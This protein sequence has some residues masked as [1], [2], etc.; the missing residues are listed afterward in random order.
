MAADTRDAVYEAVALGIGVGFM[1][2]FGTYRSDTLRRIRV[3]EFAS[4]VDEV[5]FA[6]A[7]ERNSLVD[8]FFNVARQLRPDVLIQI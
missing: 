3:P 6:L 4:T 1:W 5:V 8:L 2:R 7:D